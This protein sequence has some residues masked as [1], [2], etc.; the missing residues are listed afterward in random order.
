MW[1]TRLY[2]F[3]GTNGSCCPAIATIR[4]AM[5]ENG[6][7]R[8]ATDQSRCAIFEEAVAILWCEYARPITIGEVAWRLSV[9]PRQ[10]QRIFTDRAGMGFRSYLTAVRMSNAAELLGATDM[11]VKDVAERVGYRDP[12][13]FTKA[14]KR[15]HALSPSE[16]RGRH[17]GAP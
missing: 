8:A 14:F 9:S 13:Q 4:N 15:T 7:R 3:G 1:I 2:R 16:W 6:V 10:L 17:R 5:G 12:S 11:P